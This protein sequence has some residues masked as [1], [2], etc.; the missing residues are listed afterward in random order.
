[1]GV[2]K[3]V[4][5]TTVDRL[6]AD[7]IGLLQA[8]STTRDKDQIDYC[9]QTR[10]DQ[11]MYY[12]QHTIQIRPRQR[13]CRQY[14][15]IRLDRL[16]VRQTRQTLD[17]LLQIDSDPRSQIDLLSDR[18]AIFEATPAVDF[19]CR[20]TRR[21]LCPQIGLRVRQCQ[22]RRRQTTAQIDVDKT[23]QTTCQ[24]DQDKTRIDYCRQTRIRLGQ[25]TVDRSFCVTGAALRMTWHQFFVAGAV[26]QTGGVEKS[27]T[28]IGTRLVS[29]ALNFRFL[30][31]VSQNCFVVDVVKFKN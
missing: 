7:Q 14:Q 31:E 1:M 27:Q 29:A 25:T 12:W 19:H 10:I 4:D 18:L 3:T 6:D 17:R 2:D 26:L 28:S 21:I 11:D 8:R 23:R 13:Y 5:T 16:L 22:I 30:K 20:Q 15:Y 9:R 24:I